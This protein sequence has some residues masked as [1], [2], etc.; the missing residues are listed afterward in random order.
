LSILQNLADKVYGLLF[1]FCR[2]YRPFNDNDCTDNGVSS[3]NI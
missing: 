1:D 2:G 3:Y